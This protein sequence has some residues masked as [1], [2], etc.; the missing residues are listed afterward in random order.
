MLDEEREYVNQIKPA[1]NHC[2]TGIYETQD[3]PIFPLTVLDSNSERLIITEGSITQREGCNGLANT[4][5][6]RLSIEV[7]VN[8]FSFNIPNYT[9]CN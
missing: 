9:N 6:I 1:P 3:I 5:F 4:G 8:C 2:I 7:D